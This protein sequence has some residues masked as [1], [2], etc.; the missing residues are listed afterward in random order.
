MYLL[1]LLT[2]HSGLLN[3]AMPQI[4]VTEH[5]EQAQKKK[6]FLPSLFLC[7]LEQHGRHPK[8][9]DKQTYQVGF[10]RVL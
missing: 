3:Y 6:C 9:T 4:K 2:Q 1:F 8:V 7:I 10:V 5:K